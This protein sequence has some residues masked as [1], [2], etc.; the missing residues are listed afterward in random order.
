MMLKLTP[1]L[2]EQMLDQYVS[3]I[4]NVYYSV[5]QYTTLKK[6]KNPEFGHFWRSCNC[7]KVTQNTERKESIEQ[8][9]VKT[10]MIKV[11][12]FDVKYLWI[13]LTKPLNL[14]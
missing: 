10:V 6:T 2:F 14:K 4:N 8:K 11:M 5:L 3:N 9:R 1:T 13:S 12:E 7:C